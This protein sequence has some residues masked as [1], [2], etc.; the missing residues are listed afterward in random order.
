M[1]AYS[2]V[3]GLFPHPISDP[4]G[5]SYGQPQPASV[6]L[7]P[8][9]WQECP[10]YLRGIDLFNFG[11]YWE[12]HEAWEAIWHACGRQGPAA[13]FI[14][15]LI[16]LAVVGVK[17]REGRSAGAQWHAGRAAELFGAP[18]VGSLVNPQA[19]V[20]G[21]LLGQLQEWA[22]RLAKHL[23]KT[24]SE[25]PATVEVFMPFVLEPRKEDWEFNDR[26]LRFR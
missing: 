25:P 14:K 4:A 17:I 6:A 23:P 11:Y 10:A 2:F 22:L 18:T 26:F 7:D 19:T 24:K 20:A 1:P 13:D 16:Q 15:G 12:A 3:P 5:H 21:L 9:S 8:N